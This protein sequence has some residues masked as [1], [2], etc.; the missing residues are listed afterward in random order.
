MKVSANPGWD[1]KSGTCAAHWSAM[2]GDSRKPLRAWEIAGSKSRSKGSRP[3]L[4]CNSTQADTAPGTVTEFQPN[5]GTP[6]SPKYSGVHAAGERPHPF[7]PPSCRPSQT[8]A[9]KAG[10]RPLGTG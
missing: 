1:S 10:P 2:V 5:R 7:S 3:N 4:A 9:E 8:M 6:L